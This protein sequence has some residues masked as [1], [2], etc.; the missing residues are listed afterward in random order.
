MAATA[1]RKAA[2]EIESTFEVYSALVAE[3]MEVL[4][5]A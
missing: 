5:N 4:R 3:S 2:A 1:E